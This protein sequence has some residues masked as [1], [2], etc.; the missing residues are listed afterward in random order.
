MILQQADTELGKP[1]AA[2]L[3]LCR[4]SQAQK[5]ETKCLDHHAGF[6][7]PQPH[8]T[9]DDRMGCLESQRTASQWQAIRDELGAEF[10]QELVGAADRGG[11]INQPGHD[12]RE[13][14]S[15]IMGRLSRSVIGLL[16]RDA[17]FLPEPI[18][19]GN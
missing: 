15:M 6:C 17:D 5:P 18:Y 9:G 1:V 7:T 3:A 13:F 16:P 8:A 11:S 19:S 12:S 14:H 4:L 2:D 10:R